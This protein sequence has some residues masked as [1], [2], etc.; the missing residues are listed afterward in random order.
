MTKIDKSRTFLPVHIAVMTVSD[1]RDLKDDH[2]G[3]TLIER[4]EDSG[5]VVAGRRI[6]KDEIDEIFGQLREWIM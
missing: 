5:H 6:V 4:I 2:S 3:N 1:T